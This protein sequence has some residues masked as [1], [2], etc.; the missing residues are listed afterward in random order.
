MRI[1]R[2]DEMPSGDTL[3]LPKRVMA[4]RT[5][6]MTL[7]QIVEQAQQMAAQRAARMPSSEPILRMPPV[8]P[9]SDDHLRE[10][11]KG[12]PSRARR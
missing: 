8:G 4:K 2:W 5:A 10:I 11:A 6:D 3:G 7:E 9:Y 12:R 1:N